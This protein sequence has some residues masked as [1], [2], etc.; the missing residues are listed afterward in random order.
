MSF[1]YA[2]VSS[3]WR[4]YELEAAKA[5]FGSE[6]TIDDADYFFWRHNTESVNNTILQRSLEIESRY[7][8]ANPNGKIINPMSSFC[9]T[10]NKDLCFSRWQEEGI[11]SPKFITFNSKQ[12]ILDSGLIYPFLIRLNDGVTGEDTF[13]VTNEK[14]LDKFLP[15]V[16]AAYSRNK[17]I[18]TKKIAVEFIDTS[19]RDNFKTSFRIIVAGKSVIVGYARISDDWL[20]ITKQ[21]TDNK[22]EHFVE[23]NKRL[24]K[25]IFNNY[26]ELVRSVSVL[27]LHHVGI[28][29]IADKDDNLYFLEVQ[30]FYFCG[31]T[32]RTSPPFWNPYKPPELVKWL[33]DD[34][35]YL[36]QEMPMYYSNWLNKRNHF[37]L[38]YKS[39]KE[40]L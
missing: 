34:K 32:N 14:E 37:N 20:A 30:P 2:G 27:G 16:D 38:C 15:M 7:L 31:N 23:Q 1:C 40:S 33:V 19:I 5:F 28:D 12:D 24:E 21:F 26:D 36:S 35:E 17:R 10:N 4:P 29:A 3:Y 22:K 25:L 6:A 8:N 13:L 9:Y 18:E 11:R 39:L